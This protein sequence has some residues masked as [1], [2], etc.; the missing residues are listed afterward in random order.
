MVASFRYFNVGIQSAKGRSLANNLAQEKVE[1]LKN[2]S[3][4]RVLVTT[5]TAVP[6]ANF[7]PAMVYD[8]HPNGEESL[9][10]GGINFR[11]RVYIRK[12]SE[13][14]STGLLEYKNWND[15]DTGLKEIAV[16]VAWA[17]GGTWKKVELRNLLE[18]PDRLNLSAS[19]AG[20]VKDAA[21]SVNISSVVVRAQENPSRYAYTDVNG[22]YSFEI[23]PGTYTLMASMEGYF[24]KTRPVE[25]VAADD[26]LTA[27]DFL[28]TRMSSGTVTGSVFLRDHLVIS[29]VVGSSVSAAGQEQEWIEVYNPTTWTWTMAN[30]LGPDPANKLVFVA[31]TEAAVAEKTPLLDYRTLSLPPGAYYLFANTGTITAAGVVKSADAVYDAEAVPN[32]GN[33]DDMIL[34]GSP[35]PGGYVSVKKVV[36]AATSAVLDGVGWNASANGVGVKKVAPAWEGTAIVQSLGLQPGEEY[37]RKT[38]ASNSTPGVGRC[39]D[40][41]DNENDFLDH[42][43]LTHQPH[44]SADAEVCQSGTPAA[45]AAVFAE[46]GLSST[47]IA[48]AAGYFNL[49]G[50]ATGYWTVYASSGAFMA[51]SAAVG[52]LTHGFVY[53]AG[54]LLLSSSSSYGYVSGLVTDVGGNPLQGIKMYA[55]GA[56]GFTRADGRYT[57]LSPAGEN[58]VIANYQTYD[59][60]YIEYSQMGVMIEAGRIVDPPVDFTL[61][62]G[63]RLAGWVT[64]NG[65]DP[66][67][68]VPVVALK[69]GVEQGNTV[70][71]ADGKFLVWGSG[72][73]VGT[74]DVI[75]RLEAG[76]AASP[77][78]YTV[79][80]GAG[81]T[82][83]VGTFTVTGAMGYISG[84]V[85]AGALPITT[86]VLIYATTGTIAS[87]PPTLDST[88]RSGV[89]AYYAV[90]SDAAG[91]YELAVRGGYSYNLYAWY[92]TWGGQTPATSR[93]DY[94]AVTVAPGDSVERNFQW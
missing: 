73:A 76:E 42:V 94:S 83:F 75:P 14:P 91:H 21:S 77:S 44:N 53:N 24:L 49:A 48:D 11:R 90:S 31:Y 32:F 61:A 66:L 85:K 78:T 43:P 60:D 18:N 45:G 23:E 63:G 82:L 17:E 10:V 7:S 52:G 93:L 6:D 64:T 67:P 12:V 81:E 87:V 34:T 46:D 56:P 92:T 1:Y 89:V 35:G 68:N 57:V 30:G 20:N 71:G 54:S 28:L 51:S 22:N 5:D 65:V 86:G 27:R 8:A 16:F 2:R 13:N 15:P 3:Y 19:F 47:A 33:A 4:Y 70:S 29:Q 80:L 74:Y 41:N 59:P 84:S 88:L 37:V 26:S 62:Q 9:T 40:F 36:D 72:I 25:A 38:D 69:G 55:G 50:V 39:R 58:N 79:T